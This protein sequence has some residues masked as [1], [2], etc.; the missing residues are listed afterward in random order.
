MGGYSES[1]SIALV[2]CIRLVVRLGCKREVSECECGADE[3]SEIK[4]VS[5]STGEMNYWHITKV[6]MRVRIRRS[7]KGVDRLNGNEFEAT[8]RD[9]VP[10]HQNPSSQRTSIRYSIR[11]YK[12]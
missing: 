7:F 4:C 3:R 10:K 2:V 12:H 8:I 11:R 6:Q 5:A 9:A 1:L